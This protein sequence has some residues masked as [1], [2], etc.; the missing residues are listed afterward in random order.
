M[1]RFLASGLAEAGIVVVSG[2]ARGIDAAAHQ[3]ALESGTIAVMASGVDVIYPSENRSLGHEIPSRGLRLSEA[4]MGQPAQAR[5]FPSRNR[6]VSG[7]SQAVVVIEA[8]LKSGSLITARGAL[9]QGRDVMA[10]PG[11]PFDARAAGCNMLIRDGAVLVR[12]AADVM[13]A[14]P[15]LS[16][17]LPAGTTTARHARQA[18]RGEPPLP[19]PHMPAAPERISPLRAPAA[20]GRDTKHP[21]SGT[22]AGADVAASARRPATAPTAGAGR[23]L[24]ETAQLHQQ[25]LD[26]LG[27]SPLGEDQLIRDLRIPAAAVGPALTELELE[28]RISRQPGGLLARTI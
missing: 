21:A 15:N 6:I 19:M 1:A 12:S 8:A 17:P 28:G 13:E 23:N 11:H 10:V 14:L 20:T 16:A 27:P 24:R 2:L 4:A 26:R 22:P 7:L 3:A 5:H 18:R 25:I 9:E